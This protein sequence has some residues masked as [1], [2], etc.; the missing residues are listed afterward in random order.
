MT[1]SQSTSILGRMADEAAARGLWPTPKSRDFSQLSDPLLFAEVL[2][3]AH[4]EHHVSA[5][6]LTSE[7][8]GLR[9]ILRHLWV[10]ERPTMTTIKG[11]LSAMKSFGWLEE[12]Q[13]AYLRLTPDGL[14]V[15]RICKQN[16]KLFRRVLA[17]Q[18]HRR[19]VIPGWIVSRLLS[20]NPSGQGEI[21]LPS[22][23]KDW[24]PVPLPW[25]RRE[26]TP[27]L[28]L[29]TVR[30]A[31]T[32][33]KFFPGSFPVEV[34]LWLQHVEANWDKIGSQARRKVS[35]RIREAKSPDERTDIGTYA[36]RGRLSQAMREAAIELLFSAY[37]PIQKF[38]L[39][40]KVLEFRSER[41][42]IPPRAFRAWC[43][44]LD[45]LEF[46]FYTDW[47]P[48]ISGRLL[49]PCGAFRERA[50]T[51][52]FE[53]LSEISD[54]RGRPLCL[55]QPTWEYL[56]GQFINILLDSYGHLSQ[57]VGALYLSLLDVRDEVC[58]RLRL[59]STIFDN[60][61]ETAYRELIRE[62]VIIGER[63]S[64]SLESDIRPEQR[65]GYGMLRR[66]VYI[67]G[68][69]HSLIAISRRHRP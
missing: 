18:M 50:E 1:N 22:P 37:H 27:E 53:V 7:S 17:E 10:V 31:E 28:K 49:F 61:L 40:M 33:N 36:P 2:E 5:E 43:P 29:Q 4:K 56:K 63:V 64:I 59:S 62:N 30:A 44:R 47:H 21:V 32:A 3:I 52:P 6:K 34:E 48:S 20:L 67:N 8:E 60:L 39:P 69:P 23:P 19:Y 66:P 46:I 35:K 26:W 15:Y 51:P 14:Q 57:R 25:G 11:L 68:V 41:H 16:K 13:P 42:P 65:S 58:R 24:Q 38:Q 9:K 12:S 54:P 55:Y 45:A